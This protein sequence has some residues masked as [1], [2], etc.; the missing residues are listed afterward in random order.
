[1]VLKH[2]EPQVTSI[3][4]RAS[5]SMVKA[6]T[7]FQAI[8]LTASGGRPIYTFP[9]FRV[10]DYIQSKC[11][12]VGHDYASLP[13][14]V[15]QTYAMWIFRLFA[16]ARPQ[17]LTL[18]CLESLQFA[19]TDS[20]PAADPA[21]LNFS[22]AKGFSYTCYFSKD[23]QSTKLNVNKDRALSQQQMG[24]WASITNIILP[25]LIQGRPD[26]RRLLQAWLLA[27]KSVTVIRT[28]FK[29]KEINR[30]FDCEAGVFRNFQRGSGFQRCNPMFIQIP[31]PSMEPHIGMAC[32]RATFSSQIL[33]ILHKSGAVDKDSPLKAE[34][35]RHVS[36]NYVYQYLPG[37][38]PKHL[39]NVRH[40]T[41]ATFKNQYWL[42]IDDASID[43]INS[44]S[45]LPTSICSFLLLG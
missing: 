3:L 8:E 18:I 40:S 21:A 35:I 5:K 37:L 45:V 34:H 44:H 11:D 19:V 29:I 1:M 28:N 22:S 20:A 43:N 24:M 10:W 6:A 12:T 36:L 13:F 26:V 9:V 17:D 25:P 14:V 33:R 32:A 27:R 38:F 2:C 7:K 30:V 41:M 15:L 31:K 16:G 42:S 4:D 39:D 23:A